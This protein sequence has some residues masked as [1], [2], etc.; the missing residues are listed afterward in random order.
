MTNCACG[1]HIPTERLQLGYKVCTTCGD[2]FAIKNKKFGYVHYG[3]KTSGSI[4]LTSKDGLNNYKKVSYRKN[5]GCNLAYA[6]RL[7]T[8]F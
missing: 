4:V 3:H 2:K 1:N 7:S 8:T 5:K 6:S